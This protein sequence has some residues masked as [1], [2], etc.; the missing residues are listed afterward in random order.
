MQ[1]TPPAPERLPEVRPERL[2]VVLLVLPVLLL[3]VGERRLRL[4]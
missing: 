1:R 4:A 3:L 2:V